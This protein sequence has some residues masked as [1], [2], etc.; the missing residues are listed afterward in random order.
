MRPPHQVRVSAGDRDLLLEMRRMDRVKEATQ[1]HGHIHG[2]LQVKQRCKV[3]SFPKGVMHLKSSSLKRFEP[4]FDAKSCGFFILISSE[5]LWTS[6][7][8]S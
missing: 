6:R 1:G 4:R 7:V 5:W 3:I 2:S 8:Q